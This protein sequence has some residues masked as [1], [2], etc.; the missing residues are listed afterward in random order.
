MKTEYAFGLAI[1]TP[2]WWERHRSG[3]RKPWA[4]EV[5]AQNRRAKEG[6]KVI[7]CQTLQALLSTSK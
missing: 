6:F 5:S 1:M 3:D 4:F 7:C 2:F